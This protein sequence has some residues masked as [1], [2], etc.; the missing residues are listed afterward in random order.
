MTALP[1]LD[2]VLGHAAAAA[3]AAVL[4]LGAIDKLRDLASF[5]EVLDNYRLLPAALLKPVARAL[6]MTELLA[7]VLL[8]PGATRGFGA[9]AALALLALVTAAVVINLAR[10]RTAIDC[11]CGGVALPLSWSLVLRNLVLAAAAVAA[12]APSAAR[13]VVWLDATAAVFA[14]LFLLGLYGV[15][16]T[17]M[18]QQP[19]LMNLRNRP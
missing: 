3:L 5:D 19:L 2:P 13:A 12:A 14:A 9:A 7:G 4:L 18:A 16:N 15:A 11:G 6:P 8:L 17:L 10:G 1:A